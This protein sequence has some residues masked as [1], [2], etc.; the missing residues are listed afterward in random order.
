MNASM[1]SFQKI[2]AAHIWIYLPLPFIIDPSHTKEP[3]IPQ[4][5]FQ[6][7]FMLPQK[8]LLV[9]WPPLLIIHNSFSYLLIILTLTMP[10]RKMYLTVSVWKE[11][12]DLVKNYD[13]RYCKKWAYTDPHALIKTRKVITV[14]GFQVY[15]RDKDLIHITSTFY[16]PKM[17]IVGVFVSII[18]FTLSVELVFVLVLFLFHWFLPVSILVYALLGIF[19]L[20]IFADCFNA[21]DDSPIRQISCTDYLHSCYRL[22]TMVMI[23]CK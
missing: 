23:W 6:L 9:L 18:S 8:I 16:G 17:Q 4:I 1:I 13:K 20:Y 12:T 11:D 19:K 2:V 7:P 3:A 10:W 14:M 5:C 22:L 21:C 15:F